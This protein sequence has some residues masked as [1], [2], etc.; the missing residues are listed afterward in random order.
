MFPVTPEYFGEH[1]AMPDLARLF[2]VLCFVLLLPACAH[3]AQE[4]APPFH[5]GVNGDN[6][7][8]EIRRPGYAAALKA[9][10][11]DFVV[12]HVS[13]EEME[14][15]GRLDELVRFFRSNGLRYLFNTELVN[16]VPGVPFFRNPDGTYRWD[17]KPAIMERL[18]DDPLFMGQV[19]DEP[20]LMQSLNG[21]TVNGRTVPPYFVDSRGMS[22]LAAYEAVVGKIRELS[23]YQ[24][25]YGKLAVFE[26]VFPDYAHAA[27][28]G[29]AILAPKFLK[30]T[31]N[32][33]MYFVYA[34]AARQYRQELLFACVDLWFLD[35]FPE[36]GTW[37]PGHHTPRELREA[38]EYA[39]RMGVDY[40]YVEHV[41]AL[42]NTETGE[43]T[44]YGRAVRDFNA[45]KA[46]LARVSWR[47]W[48]PE[49]VVRRF[50]D[51]YWGQE[52]STFIPDHPY[53]SWQPKPAWMRNAAGQWLRLLSRLSA[54]ALPVDANNWNALKSPAF[55]GRPYKGMVGLPPMLVL[56]HTA[57]LP[58]AAEGGPEVVDLAADMPR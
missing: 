47:D 26:M 52:Y 41:K 9:L 15:P 42:A 39:Y 21:A 34:G 13:P 30:E 44:E 43:L 4:Q 25:G 54:G 45:G 18:R 24:A 10:G 3:A 5:F 53:G 57:P 7:K 20:M 14:Q 17:I 36:N 12:W 23:A 27:A 2:R 38:L 56:D 32:D 16:Y 31:S 1:T 33:L 19:Y 29:G 11:V 48:T 6:W 28:R 22:P 35:K 37:S 8:G 49:L 51:G 58:A 55:A 40:A 46:G 50:P